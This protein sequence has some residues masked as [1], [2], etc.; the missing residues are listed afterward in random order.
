[1]FQFPFLSRFLN[2]LAK[3]L[4]AYSF[5]LPLL[6]KVNPTQ[7][8]MFKRLTSTQEKLILYLLQKGDFEAP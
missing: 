3:S 4:F 5:V 8:A 6:H 7:R 2:P 1:M